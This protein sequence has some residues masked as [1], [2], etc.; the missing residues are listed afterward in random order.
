MILKTGFKVG[1]NFAKHLESSLTMGGSYVFW[2]FFE[3]DPTEYWEYI[4]REPIGPENILLLRKYNIE[5]LYDN[6][7]LAKQIR[8][9][10]LK[11][12]YGDNIICCNTCK[13]KGEISN[14]EWDETKKESEEKFRVCPD[15]KG[16]GFL[17]L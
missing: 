12:Q 7:E 3:K 11:E 5:K 14:R 9:V 8:Y 6:K 4:C 17:R 2:V 15:C 13:G 10:N 1:T 16:F